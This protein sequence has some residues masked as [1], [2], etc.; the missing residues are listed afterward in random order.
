MSEQQEPPVMWT[1]C[2][3]CG[4]TVRTDE[5]VRKWGA[6][7]QSYGTAAGNFLAA[8]QTALVD[9][10]LECEEENR[11]PPARKL[12]KKQIERNKAL[13]WQVPL[14]LFLP[15]VGGLIIMLLLQFV[16]LP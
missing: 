9:I 16:L 5:C 7:G 13:N 14:L 2:H 3:Q 8:S 6:V 11:P 1:R 4:K 12:T 10:C 15:V